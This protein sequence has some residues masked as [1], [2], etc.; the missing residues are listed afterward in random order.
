MRMLFQR[1]IFIAV[2]ALIPTACFAAQGDQRV[3]ATIMNFSTAGVSGATPLYLACMNASGVRESCG[4]VDTE[5]DPLSLHTTGGNVNGQ[6]TVESSMTVHGNIH[7]HSMDLQHTGFAA[8]ITASPTATVATNIVLPPNMGSPGYRWTTD[9]IGNTYWAPPNTNLKNIYY[10]NAV[11]SG[12]PP[13]SLLQ[14]SPNISVDITTRAFVIPQSAEIIVS[15]YITP[16]LGL[17]NI[18]AGVWQ[19]TAWGSKSTSN[20]AVQ[21]YAK[22]Y[23]YDGEEHFLLQ[24]AVATVPE[25]PIPVQ[26][27]L[28]AVYVSTRIASTSRIVIRYYAVGG[29]GPQAATL[30]AYLGDSLYSSVEFPADPAV[31]NSYVPYTGATSNVSLGAFSIVAGSVTGTHYGSGANLTNLPTVPYSGATSNVT[32]GTYS[33]TAGSIT[34]T[35]YGSGANLTGLPSGVSTTTVWNDTVGSMSFGPGA[36]QQIRYYNTLFG[37]EAAVGQAGTSVLGDRNSVFGRRAGYSLLYGYDNAF[38]GYHTGLNAGDEGYNAFFG[39]EVAQ[40]GYTGSYNVG[41]GYRSHYRSYGSYNTSVGMY[42]GFENVYGARNVEVGAYAGQ[43]AYTTSNYF[44][45]VMVGYRAGFSMITGDTNILIG[46]YTGDAITTGDNNILIG[47]NPTYPSVTVSSYVNIG[48]LITGIV[49]ASSVTVQGTLSTNNLSVNGS[50]NAKSK[51]VTSSYTITDSDYMIEASTTTAFTVTLPT[52]SGRTGRI[53][54]IKNDG[55]GFI[56]VATT[57]GELI[58]GIAN[59]KMSVKNNSVKVMANSAEWKVIGGRTMPAIPHAIL[60]TTFTITMASAS[61]EYA[62]HIGTA[63]DAHGI[64]F[65]PDGKIYFPEHGE[66]NVQVSAVAD[67]SGAGNALIDL[68]VKYNGNNLAESNTQVGINS[69]SL[70]TVVAVPFLFDIENGGDYIQFFSHST[71]STSRWLAIAAQTGP[72]A[73]PACPSVIISVTK[74][75]R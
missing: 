67:N 40:G 16:A 4:G 36:E 69:A 62:I 63:S 58:D 5:V 12:I 53:Y 20:R 19:T 1:S 14:S 21:V 45:N 37:A 31:V 17:T 50:Q 68:W 60:I 15:T 22:F 47:N 18:P 7:A 24:T 46:P 13:Y 42:S 51:V 23:I 25:S 56:T 54:E 75:G 33:I 3:N 27:N 30:S 35:H 38:F 49:G 2:L 64:T 32:L 26:F 70:Q 59:F 8:V 52:V 65:T 44:D 48:N 39:S 43:G 29:S 66:Y 28:N 9:G 61:A 41:V 6:V 74:V 34:G 71:L 55:I 72:P 57:G 73:I 10:L 11:P